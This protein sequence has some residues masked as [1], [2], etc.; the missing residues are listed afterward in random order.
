MTFTELQELVRRACEPWTLGP[1][2]EDVAQALFQATVEG[3]LTQD[4]FSEL[5]TDM[6]SAAAF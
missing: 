6:M 3:V 1:T 2:T 4:Q 5:F